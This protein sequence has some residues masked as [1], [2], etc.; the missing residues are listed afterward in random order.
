MIKRLLTTK[1]VNKIISQFPWDLIEI[2]LSNRLILRKFNEADL[3]WLFLFVIHSST[4]LINTFKQK[5]N[6]LKMIIE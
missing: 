6:M 2:K 1:N 4:N 3:F 5:K